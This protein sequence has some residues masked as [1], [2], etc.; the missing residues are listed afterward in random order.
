MAVY[1]VHSDNGTVET[2]HNLVEGKTQA[3]TMKARFGV[4]SHI[5]KEEIVYSTETLD[6]LMK[7]DTTLRM[8]SG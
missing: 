4:K 3:D 8:N 6:E 2:F 5:V 1:K 7:E